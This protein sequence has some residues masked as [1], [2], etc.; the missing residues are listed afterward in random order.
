MK[1]GPK[2]IDAGALHAFAQQAYWGFRFLQE[3]NALLWKRI[4]KAA[5]TSEIRD[6][7]AAC[8]TPGA[9]LG[10]GYGAEGAMTWL[11]NGN[12]AFQI[13]EAKRHRRYPKSSNR[14]SSEDRRMI[15]LGIAVAAGVFGISVGTGLRKLA[16]ANLG[17]ESLSKQ[18]H[19]LDGFKEIVERNAYLMAEPI[20]NY[21]L[22]LG[23]G[24]YIRQNDLPCEIPDDC[25]DGYIIHGY[26]NGRPVAQ[27]S[28]TLPAELADS[29]EAQGK[30]EVSE[31]PVLK[32]ANLLT[33]PLSENQ[34]VCV[35]GA[36]IAAGDTE[37]ALKAL[38]DHKRR[39]HPDWNDESH[40]PK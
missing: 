22:P 26:V 34:V 5:D 39:V 9:M 33:T 10:A 3:N 16:E 20:G 2:E 36:T 19:S 25:V 40:K 13:V 6:I 23:D 37:T 32:P 21:L 24:T 29:P 15:F 17:L 18:V 35:C 28:R 12:V 27:F 4:K 11:Q 14:P 7:G 1:R 8:A 31:N 38:A 30:V